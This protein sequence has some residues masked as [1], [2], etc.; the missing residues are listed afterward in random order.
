MGIQ[1]KTK[2]TDWMK[3][4]TIKAKETLRNL[5]AVSSNKMFERDIISEYED[6][7]VPF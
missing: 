2:Q 1:N 6:D 3:E 5:C 7:D 4:N